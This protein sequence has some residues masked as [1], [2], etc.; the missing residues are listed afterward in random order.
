MKNQPT[1]ALPPRQ[2]QWPNPPFLSSKVVFTQTVMMV[3]RR[4]NAKRFLCSY[5]LVSNIE[6]NIYL[7]CIHFAVGKQ[8]F[9]DFFRVGQVGFYL[10]VDWVRDPK[11]CIGHDWRLKVII[12]IKIP[13]V[14]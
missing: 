2:L 8:Q 3:V 6:G 9:L 13:M 10:L 1:F 5:L 12:T 11:D 4:M 14:K 7:R